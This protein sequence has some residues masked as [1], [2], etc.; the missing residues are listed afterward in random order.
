MSVVLK[1]DTHRVR[2]KRPE[3]FAPQKTPVSYQD[4]NGN[5]TQKLIADTRA[6]AMS[7]AVRHAMSVGRN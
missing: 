5:I 1:Q 7:G 4:G 3:L 6:T 2:M